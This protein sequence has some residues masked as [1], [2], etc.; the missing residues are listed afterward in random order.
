MHYKIKKY[1]NWVV[2]NQNGDFRLPLRPQFVQDTGSVV[3]RQRGK[4]L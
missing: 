3:L 2:S 1:S 4:N